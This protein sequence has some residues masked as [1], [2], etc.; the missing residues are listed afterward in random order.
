MPSDRLFGDYGNIA[1]IV[2]ATGVEARYVDGRDVLAVADVMRSIVERLRVEGRPAFLECGVF[3]VRP[4][5]LSDPDYRY[6]ERDAGETWLALNDPIALLRGRLEMD[7]RPELDA[8]DTEVELLVEAAVASA[9]AAEPT[10]PADAKANVYATPG[11]A[12]A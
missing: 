2:A 4:H 5:S 3:R 10:P 9:E 11:L 1:A 6:R 7:H 8:I 12:G